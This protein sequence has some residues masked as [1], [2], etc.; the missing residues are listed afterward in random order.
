ME[1]VVEMVAA[2]VDVVIGREKKNEGELV[3][4]KMERRRGLEAAR[5]KFNMFMV[6]KKLAK[7]WP[8]E[9][10]SVLFSFRVTATP[11]VCSFPPIFRFLPEKRARY[12]RRGS[13]KDEVQIFRE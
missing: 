13:N 4:D 10:S 1:S 6:T 12:D 5:L 11:H 3:Q 9:S 8:C 2:G 7:Q